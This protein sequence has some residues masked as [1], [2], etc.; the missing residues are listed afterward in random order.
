M[1]FCGVV[2]GWGGWPEVG[3]VGNEAAVGSDGGVGGSWRTPT[4]ASRKEKGL[5]SLTALC[6]W[7]PFFCM[8]L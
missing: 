4:S 2:G 1:L 8:Y 6:R 3:G 7:P 5:E